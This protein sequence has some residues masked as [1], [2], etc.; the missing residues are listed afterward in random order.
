MAGSVNLFMDD[1]HILSTT[2]EFE[3]YPAFDMTSDELSN[4][5][6]DFM[7]TLVFFEEEADGF[8]TQPVFNDLDLVI[9][10]YTS[11][12]SPTS[13]YPNGRTSP[14]ST[15]TVEKVRRMNVPYNNI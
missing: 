5:E 12:G 13:F 6:G 9:T 2:G 1:R 8:S 7:A 3:E 15:N 14:D 11:G 10:A 4:L